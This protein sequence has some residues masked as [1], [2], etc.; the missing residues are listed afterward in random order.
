MASYRVEIWHLKQRLSVLETTINNLVDIKFLC[1]DNNKY[2]KLVLRIPN[3]GDPSRI[4][5]K[6]TT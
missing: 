1:P 5:W 2:Y 6:E 3:N 4:E